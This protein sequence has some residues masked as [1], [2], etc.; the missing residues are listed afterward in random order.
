M[1]KNHI[2]DS[3]DH[4]LKGHGVHGQVRPEQLKGLVSKK[5][6]EVS[7]NKRSQQTQQYF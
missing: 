4:L 5:S 1:F 6:P 7:L 3:A 2:R